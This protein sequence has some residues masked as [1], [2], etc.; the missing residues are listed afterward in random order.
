VI[1]VDDGS[2]DRSR[3]VILK[4][5]AE[6]PSIKLVS[7]SRNFGQQAA[8]AAGLAHA[9]GDAVVLMDADLQDPPSVIPDLVAAW[10]AGHEV[11]LAVR[12]NRDEGL[13]K[14]VP[15]RIFYRLM[16]WATDIDITMD[17]GD[18]CLLDRKAADA[19]RALP[20]RTR[21]TRGLRS[22]IGF[23]QTTV[24]YDRP[25]RAAGATKYPLSR[26]IKLAVDALLAFSSA[27]LRLATWLGFAAATAGT[28]YLAV[29]VAAK[30]FVG[31][32]PSG[33]TSI[34]AIA[35]LLGGSQL[36]VM[37]VLGQYVARVYDETKGRPLY[38][39]GERHG[40]GD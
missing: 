14:R 13:I 33:W 24:S 31:H 7:L 40:L 8:M 19:L 4:L 38:V 25:A 23:R 34:I 39:V 6:Q 27:P 29:A 26:L 15:A 1:F 18:F 20:E 32:P 11:V 2:T 35:L 10:R 30:L 3:E 17:T 22:W 21:W 5:R 37:G 36:V 28:V 9:S 12:G 16:T